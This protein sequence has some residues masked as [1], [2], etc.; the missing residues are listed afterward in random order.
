MTRKILFMTGVGFL[1]FVLLSMQN[2]NK[3][4]SDKIDGAW[5]SEMQ[6]NE[7]TLLFADG[8]CMLSV[9]NKAKKQF[10]RTSGGPYILDSG[11]IKIN[12]EFNSE[13]K[14]DV[15]STH[16][17]GYTLSKDVLTTTTNGFSL[18]WKRVDS[19]NENITGNWRITQRKQDDKMVDI[20]LRARRTL[21]LLTA[22]RFQW[23]AINIETGEFFGTG[24]GTYSFKNGSYTE[25]IEFFSRDSSRV[26][27]SLSFEGKIED[28]NWIHSGK[29]SK[30][31]PIYEMWSRGK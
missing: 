26:G 5:V 4:T 21:K 24:G 3:A 10:I 16:V 15:G 2:V 31:D 27:M 14:S 9:F 13:D 23:A 8:Y 28:G 29:S 7:L 17:H 1:T 12:I 18:N 11:K 19:G 25:N 20:P 6:G 22:T 30:G